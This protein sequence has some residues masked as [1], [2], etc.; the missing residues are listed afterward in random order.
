MEIKEKK[1][2]CPKCFKQV[3]KQPG[4]DPLLSA[5]T[6]VNCG[7][8]FKINNV[9]NYETPTIEPTKEAPVVDTDVIEYDENTEYIEPVDEAPVEDEVEETVNHNES[10]PIVAEPEIINQEVAEPVE[11]EAS[12]EPE[13]V[14][15]VPASQSNEE[16]EIIDVEPVETESVEQTPH[17]KNT[18]EQ[19]TEPEMVV[20]EEEAASDDVVETEPKPSDEH[21]IDFSSTAENEEVQEKKVGFFGKLFGDEKPRDNSKHVLDFLRDDDQVEEEET[22]AGQDS[23]YEDD[24]SYTSDVS[25]ASQDSESSNVS[26]ESQAPFVSESSYENPD[27]FN[28]ES[29]QARLESEIQEEPKKPGIVQ[30]FF[31]KQEQKQSEK[32][33]VRI[34]FRA[35]YVR[36]NYFLRSRFIDSFNNF[37][38][39]I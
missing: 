31:D 7:Y 11:Q 21:E 36:F 18:N 28:M 22:P 19:M 23:D 34:T 10:E 30:S 3:N 25:N 37:I 5:W 35:F 20:Q 33:V 1:Y 2:Y 6:C 32:D 24:Q 13:I 9:E 14:D 12:N 29:E 16:P 4:F 8:E 39:S 38:K 26:F 15:Q 27:P 17:E